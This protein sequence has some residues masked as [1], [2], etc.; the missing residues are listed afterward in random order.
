MKKK[1][2]LSATLLFLV[3]IGGGAQSMVVVEKDGTQHKFNT[4]YI[5]EVIFEEEEIDEN[6]VFTSLSPNAFGNG[7]VTLRFATEDESIKAEIDAYGSREASFLEPGVYT[8][9]AS[10]RPNFGTDSYTFVT[11]DGTKHSVKSG[12]MTVEKD[13]KDYTILLDLILDDDTP[14]KGKYEGGVDGYDGFLSLVP[15]VARYFENDFPE[16]EIYVKLNDEDGWS[17]ESAFDFFTTA[18]DR[19]LPAGTY[20]YSDSASKPAGTFGPSSYVDTNSPRVSHRFA[21]GSTITVTKEGD[22]YSFDMHLKT[23]TGV[24]ITLTYTGRILPSN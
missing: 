12:T 11:I 16:G 6:I 20:S 24:E 18:T 13:G 23:T 15:T 17:F 14:L 5:Q 7:N 4:D 3:Y 10:E 9:G 21:E 22:T 8:G 19:V 2:C 1:L